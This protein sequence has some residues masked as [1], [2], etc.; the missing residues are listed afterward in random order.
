MTS[1][2]PELSLK[3][4][5][6]L[7]LGVF[8]HEDYLAMY[9]DLSVWQ[10][11]VNGRLEGFNQTD[12]TPVRVVQ[13]SIGSRDDETGETET[14]TH[15]IIPKFDCDIDLSQLGSN[16]VNFYRQFLIT[17]DEKIDFETDNELGTLSVV[18]Q[19]VFLHILFSG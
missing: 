9:L 14:G 3:L 7:N 2:F 8:R 16:F 1:S 19:K 5:K 4:T 13:L 12:T 17:S 11:Y 18:A 6:V 15:L 10:D